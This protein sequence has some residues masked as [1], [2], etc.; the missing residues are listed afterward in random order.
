MELKGDKGTDY[1]NDWQSKL[2]YT[3]KLKDTLKAFDDLKTKNKKV[4]EVM[5]FDM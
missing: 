5:F 4:Y 1:V 3:S 2:V